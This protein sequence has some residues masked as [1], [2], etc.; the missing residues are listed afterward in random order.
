MNIHALVT[1]QKVEKVGAVQR[2]LQNL[3]LTDPTSNIVVH[4]L[5][6]NSGVSDFPRSKEETMLGA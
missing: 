6:A 4:G 3:D 5:S 2:A 1:S